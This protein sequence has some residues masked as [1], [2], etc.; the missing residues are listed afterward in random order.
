MVYYKVVLQA[1]GMDM[2]LEYDFDEKLVL[3]LES[4]KVP[5]LG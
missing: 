2:N 5:G 4:D 1:P 3:V